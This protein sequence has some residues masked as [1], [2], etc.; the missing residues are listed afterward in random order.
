MIIDDNISEH[1]ILEFIIFLSPLFQFFFKES[2][3]ENLGSKLGK[4]IL[5]YIGNGA[6]YWRQI[7]QIE[8][9]EVT[10]DQ[11]CFEKKIIN[12]SLFIRYKSPDYKFKT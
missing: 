12:F 2:Y 3:L 10:Q 1:H 11:L 8:S 4:K 6:E 9:P 7:R 5:F